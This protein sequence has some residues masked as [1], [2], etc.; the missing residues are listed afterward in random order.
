MKTENVVKWCFLCDGRKNKHVTNHEGL[1]LPLEVL[2][3][4]FS[5]NIKLNCFMD[6][7]HSLLFFAV[8]QIGS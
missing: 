1:V 8:A 3:S 2:N 7:W 4:T 6:I 5:K